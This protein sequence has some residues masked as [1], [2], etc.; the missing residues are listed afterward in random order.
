MSRIPSFANFMVASENDGLDGSKSTSSENEQTLFADRIESVKSAVISAIGG[1]ASFTPVA[2][3]MGLVG[4]FDAKWEFSQDSLGVSLFLFGIIYRYTI[5]KDKNEQL[6]FGAVGAFAIVRA[7]AM[8]NPPLECS[9]LPLNCGGPFYIFT[10]SM[11]FSGLAELIESL[12]AFG[13]AAACLEFC[14][15]KNILQKFPRDKQ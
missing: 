5:R 15:S 10:W 9:S 2:L 7:L 6:K 4:D 11:L 1:S 12:V 3:I 14:F 13:G 8:T